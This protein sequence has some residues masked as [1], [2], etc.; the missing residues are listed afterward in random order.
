MNAV[1]EHGQTA[2]SMAEEGG[3]DIVLRL[4]RDACDGKLY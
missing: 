4:L 1:N 3:L 2:L